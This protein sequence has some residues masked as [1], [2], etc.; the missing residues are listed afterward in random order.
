MQA[1]DLYSFKFISLIKK[2]STQSRWPVFCV[3]KLSQCVLNC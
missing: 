1:S 3:P 2:P